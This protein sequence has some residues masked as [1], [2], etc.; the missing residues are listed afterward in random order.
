MKTRTSQKRDAILNILKHTTTHP[1]A[2]WVYEQLTECYPDAGIATVYRNLKILLDQGEI[3]KI[4]VG[5]GT[6]HYDADISEHYHF[7]CK[8]CGKIYDI[9]PG[10]MSFGNIPKTVGDM[11]IEEMSVVFKG[12][13]GKCRVKE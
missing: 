5:D 4:D 2:D 8:C 6:D 10:E 12:I 3:I 1:T 9:R 13:C 11:T 7:M